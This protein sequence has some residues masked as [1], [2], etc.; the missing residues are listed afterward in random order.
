MF[1]LIKKDLTVLA[2]NK[3]ELIELLL[4]PFILISIL[5]FALGGLTQNSF[6]IDPFPVGYVNETNLEEELE[7]FAG[8]LEENGVPST[9]IDGI[10]KM[11]EDINPSEAF[12]SLIMSE[13]IQEWLM[14]EE[15]STR[16]EAEEALGQNDIEGLFVIP[17]EFSLTL[18]R[19]LFLGEE[20]T[21]ALDLELI[22]FNHVYSDIMRSIVTSFVDNYNLEVSLAMANQGQE[23]DL[24]SRSQNYGEVVSLSAEEPIS[25]FQYY[26]IGMGVMFALY[27]APTIASRAFKEKEDHVFGRLM[28]AG[29][30]P[31]T[32]LISKLLSSMG[33]TFIQLA[34]LFGLSNSVFGTFDGRSGTFWMVAG[35][36]TLL[37]SFVVGTIASLLTSISLYSNSVT[38]SS[39]FSGIVVTLFALI[40]GS[41]IPVD[42]FSDTLR[43]LG[44]WTPNGAVMTTYLQLLQ[45]FS[46]Q[47][48]W[49]L[50]LRVS[51]LGVILLISSVFIFPKRRLD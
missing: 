23:N 51:S 27:T 45:G 37:Y 14:I 5:G 43:S 47:E 7:S 18:W 46:L 21:S 40:G 13:D 9:E 15:F 32:Y 38:T 2:R 39:F 50:I 36:V 6:R 42:S 44:N 26:T 25:A 35:L 11:A 4:M 49:P 34:V 48:I 30:K 31:M 41:F 33:I 28:I 12:Q 19:N 1:N 10:L 8:Y 17:N 16:E 24:L 29:S 20:D 3:S 22:E